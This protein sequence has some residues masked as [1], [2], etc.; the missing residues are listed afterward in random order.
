MNFSRRDFLATAA[1]SSAAVALGSQG[2]AQSVP[3]NHDHDQTL[4]SHPKPTHPFVPRL[5]ALLCTQAG[6]I[7]ID[8]AFEML[9]Q[10]SDTLDA[11]LHVT[12]TQ[13][14]DPNDYS[15]GIGGLPNEECEVQLDA[16]CLHGPTRRSA[17]VGAVSKI[18]N[19]SL[20]ARAVMERTGYSSLVGL[21]A[22]RFAISQGFSKENLTTERTRRMWA[23][24]K[25]I[26]SHPELPGEGIFDPNWPTTFR[27]THFL[28]SSPQDLNQLIRKLEPL[29]IQVGLGPQFT[30]RAIFDALLP[31]STPLYVSTVNQKKEISSAAT[32]SGV[33]WRLA[34]TTSDIAMIGAGCYLDPEVGSAG[35]TGSAEANIK[36][37]GARTIVENMRRGMSPEEAGMDALHR[38]V[39]WY[40]S[41]MTALRF[42]EMVYY[43]LRNDGVYAGVSLWRG[44]RTGN[45]RQFTIHDGSRR[46]EECKFLFDSNPS[47]GQAI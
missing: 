28:P 6:T 22:Q 24:W 11:A 21:D 39:H 40:G 1:I 30:W 27:K 13:E 36:I 35:S 9:K 5:P 3:P 41:D 42:V 17:A 38:I 15:T 29:A 19:A 7:G 12:K 37:A 34:G 18:K 2:D 14:D 43:I 8:A 20:M 25:K 10:G 23:V 47:N 4:H 44:D 31:V 32:T 46:T 33:P 45:L 26:Q 16:C